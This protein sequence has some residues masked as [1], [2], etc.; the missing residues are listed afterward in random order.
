MTK[1][2]QDSMWYR[3]T[4]GSI[5]LTSSEADIMRIVWDEGE[6]VTVRDVYE[7]MRMKKSIAYTTVM[8]VMDK[9]AKK[10]FLIQDKSAAAYV[11]TA[12][13]SDAEV[14]GNILD[15][16]IDKVLAGAAEP[17]VARL[18]G[19]KKKLSQQQVKKLEERLKKKG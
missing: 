16:V 12:S 4:N 7:R 14:A 8:S 13:M 19:T 15:S 1:K 17:L 2:K 3:K 10:G 18:L 5:N 6:P 9:L 11:Y